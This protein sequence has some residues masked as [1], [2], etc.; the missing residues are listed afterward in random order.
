MHASLIRPHRYKAPL[1]HIAASE[2]CELVSLDFMKLDL[3]KGLFQHVLVVHNH[4]TKFAQAYATKNKSSKAAADKLFNEFV[5]QFGF[6]K[7]IHHD[8]GGEFNNELIVIHHLLKGSMSELMKE[9]HH[10]AGWSEDVKHHALP[11]NR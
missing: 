11:S 5:M 6:Q 1:S 4:F 3:C 10:L 2:P 8:G 9:L 7:H